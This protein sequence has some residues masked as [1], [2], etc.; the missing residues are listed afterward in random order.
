MKKTLFFLTQVVWAIK[1]HESPVGP[2]LNSHGE[3]VDPSQDKTL[4]RV[5]LFHESKT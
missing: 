4:A 5:E 1:K 3:T 2:F